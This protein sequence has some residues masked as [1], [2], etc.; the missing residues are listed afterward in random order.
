MGL[1][2]SWCLGLRLF[3]NCSIQLGNVEG[4]VAFEVKVLEFS[5]LFLTQVVIVTEWFAV[6]LDFTSVHL[7]NP[8][9]TLILQLL[10][11]DIKI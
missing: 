2:K 7:I 6:N 10:T 8:T 1:L 4:F 3:L 5:L 9:E 11:W